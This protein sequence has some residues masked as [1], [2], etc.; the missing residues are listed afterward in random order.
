MKHTLKLKIVLIVLF[1]VF[2]HTYLLF[3]GKYQIFP[4]HL[5]SDGKQYLTSLIQND[6]FY[7]FETATPAY[8]AAVKLK[9]N[10]ELEIEKRNQLI[11][12]II[13]TISNTVESNK[14]I[15]AAHELKLDPLV[16]YVKKRSILKGDKLN[17][18][19]H[20]MDSYSVQ[21]YRLGRKKAA[22]RNLGNFKS[23][24]Q[25][26]LY[27]PV[28]GFNW[29]PSFVVDTSSYETGIYLVEMI[30]KSNGG[31]WQIPFI[32]K[33]ETAPKIAFIASSYTWYAFNSFAGKSFYAD[34]ETSGENTAYNNALDSVL[35]NIGLPKTS[36][37]LPIN[38]PLKSENFI[39]DTLPETTHHSHQLRASWMLPAFAE[40]HSIQLGFYADEDFNANSSL[41]NSEIIVFDAHTEYWSNAMIAAY[42]KFIKKGGK[43]IFAGGNP[44]FKL[45]AIDETQISLVSD[46]DASLREKMTGA[47]NTG[48]SNPM[49][50]PFQVL[51]PDHWVFSGTNLKEGATFGLVSSNHNPDS[52]NQ[53]ASGWEA[54]Q[55]SAESADF[56]ILAAGKNTK[57]PSH[58]LFKQTQEGGWIFS[59]GS[60]VFGGALFSDPVCEKIMLNLLDTKKSK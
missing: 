42:E 14:K 33:P 55:G 40:A 5:I 53:G 21:I 35:M 44:A 29:I 48:V 2:T 10:A 11:S 25:D 16:G 36:I 52:I 28:K 56:T 17:V 31:F 37:K 13:K 34:S 4:Y 58:M 9:S 19:V 38:R 3:V 22:Y 57:F 7:K 41:M 18:F 26:A 1:L 49:Y 51:K 24:L 32:V 15:Q 45:V 54:D 23:T 6:I 43:V 27:S 59:A 12:P 50:S 47:V 39:S 30:S 8:T 46:I 60:I 20:A